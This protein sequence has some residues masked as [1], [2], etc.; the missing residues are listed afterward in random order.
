M[1]T[2]LNM[3]LAS[4]LGLGLINP[5]LLAQ[6]GKVERAVENA[7]TKVEQAVEGLKT[8]TYDLID[9]DITTI[10]F[11]KNS[12]KLSKSEASTLRAVFKAV[13]SDDTVDKVIVAAWGDDKMPNGGKLSDAQVDLAE[14][15]A[16]AV[17]DVLEKMGNKNVDTYNMAKDATWIGKVFETQNAEIKEAMKGKP[18]DDATA[19]RLAQQLESKGGV[20]KAVVIVKRSHPGRKA[21]AK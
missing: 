5:A 2:A 20:S 18:A 8:E 19:N 15:R 13:L 3:I 21:A 17:E 12:S 11:A 16:A 1:K 6:E 4:G 10:T 14:K 9:K 7:Q